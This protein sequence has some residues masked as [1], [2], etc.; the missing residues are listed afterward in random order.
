MR[1]QVLHYRGWSKRV[2]ENL[3]RIPHTQKTKQNKISHRVRCSNFLKLKKKRIEF[4]KIAYE[5][6]L[7]QAFLKNLRI[8]SARYV[9]KQ[10]RN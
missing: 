2:K 4:F 5:C 3:F 1:A 6:K 9:M 7:K 10:I 8:P